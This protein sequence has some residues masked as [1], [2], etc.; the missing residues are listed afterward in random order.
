MPCIDASIENPALA[1]IRMQI[2]WNTMENSEGLHV[3]QCSS[4][5]MIVL[6]PNQ[7]RRYGKLV[8]LE[9]ASPNAW[10]ITLSLTFPLSAIDRLRKVK[11]DWFPVNAIFFFRGYN[12]GNLSLFKPNLLS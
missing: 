12:M 7:V 5:R 11:V 10:E 6:C 1:P 3:Q 8:D 9:T 4:Q 2:T